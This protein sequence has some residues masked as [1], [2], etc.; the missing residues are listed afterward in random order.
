M[1]GLIL[2]ETTKRF[3]NNVILDSIDLEIDDGQFVV[4]VGPS[5][6]GKSTLLRII[7]GLTDISAGDVY[8]G[9]QKVNDV[10]PAERGIAMV[11]QSYALYP[12]MTVEQNMGFSLRMAREEKQA[13]HEKVLAA[14]R[15]L[16]LDQLLDRKPKELSGGQRQRVAIGRAIV[17]QPQI[18][19][20]DEPLSN[21][22]AELRVDMRVQIAKLHKQLKTTMIYVTHDQVEAMTMADQIVVLN[23]GQLQQVGTPMTLYHYPRNRFVASFIGSPRMNFIAVSYQGANGK[24]VDVK[25]GSK[26][27]TLPVKSSNDASISVNQE[28]FLGIRPKHL[29]IQ[30]KGALI[31]PGKIEVVEKLGGLSYAYVHLKEN[32]IQFTVEIDEDASL[33]AGKEINLGLRAADCHLFDAGGKAFQ[34]LTKFDVH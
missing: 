28:L 22:D 12:H 33:E 9:G 1:A 34:R 29:N 26:K 18:F 20:F 23:D 14:A 24:G 5:G 2:E 31:L 30:G 17:R 13:I 10:P 11:F 25:L 21:L 32:D 19:L 8:I 27:T 7:A 15:I 4:F 6:C 3:G 16:Q